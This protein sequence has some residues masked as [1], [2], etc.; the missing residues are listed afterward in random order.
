MMFTA[1]KFRSVR[2]S[3]VR[4][5]GR[6]CSGG[7]F[8]FKSRF[9]RKLRPR[10]LQSG[11]RSRL[12]DYLIINDVI[13]LL[14]RNWLYSI[15]WKKGKCHLR[16]VVTTF[17]VPPSWWWYVPRKT[18]FLGHLV[19]SRKAFA[20]S[21]RSSKKTLDSALP[22]PIVGNGCGMNLLLNSLLTNW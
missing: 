15:D 12:G 13:N 4:F 16:F 3:T 20:R 21:S 19:P 7:N 2:P 18:D 8:F 6:F 17:W 10:W 22:L 14:T 11:R 1:L 9:F 5:F